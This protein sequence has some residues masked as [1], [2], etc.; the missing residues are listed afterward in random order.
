MTNIETSKP[1]AIL[2]LSFGQGKN[3][4]PGL[5]N[6]KLAEVVKRLWLE[7]KLPLFLQWEIADCLLGILGESSDLVVREHRQKGEYLDTRE[8]IL[9]AWDFSQKKNIKK[10]IV[11][12]HPDHMPRVLLT[13][14]KI[15]FEVV[16]ADTKDVPYDP[17]S[18]QEW[19][20]SREKFLEREERIMQY[21]EEKDWI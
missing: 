4:S 16:P 12:A 14:E 9:Q 3:N 2:G 13:A 10:V 7:Y 15:G 5:T 6:E 21:C 11:V 1:Q 8:V 20:T 17:E 19:T 18:T